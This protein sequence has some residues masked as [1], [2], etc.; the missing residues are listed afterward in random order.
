MEGVAFAEGPVW[1]PDGTLVVSHLA[2][3]CLRRI[4]PATGQSEIFVRTRGSANAAQLASDSG[5]LITQNGGIDFMLYADAL[6]LTKE[7]CPPYQPVT[8]GLQRVSASGQITYLTSD[9]LHGPNDLVV[10]RDGTTYFTDPGHPSTDA[11]CSGRLMALD[12]NGNLRVIAGGFRY[13]NGIALAPDGRILVA[14]A[15]GLMWVSRSG[16]KD[17]LIESLG[18]HPGDG[19]SF[20]IDGHVYVACPLGHCIH[21]IDTDGKMLETIHLP[22]GSIVTNLCFGGSDLRT[23]FA[24][25]IAPGRVHA[26]EHMPV[27]GLPMHAWPVPPG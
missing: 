19:L 8:P 7:T 14:E 16:E 4:W 1:C 12:P 11:A 26:I 23:L 10:D 3:G 21:V 2:P 15:N 27:A 17:W 22:A 9:T 5:F 25:E 24:V 20:D 6:N 18:D 13:D